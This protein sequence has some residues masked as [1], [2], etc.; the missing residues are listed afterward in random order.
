MRRDD[1][2]LLRPAT[3]P[4]RDALTS[5]WQRL[6]CHGNGTSGDY[7]NDESGDDDNDDIGDD[8]D[9]DERNDDDGVDGSNDTGK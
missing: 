5:E 9:D 8:D 6:C 1:D 3:P 2:R 7:E 4:P